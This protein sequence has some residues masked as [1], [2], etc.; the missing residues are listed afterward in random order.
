MNRK[1]NSS[2]VAPALRPA[3]AG[4]KPG[5]PTPMIEPERYELFSSPAYHFDLNRREF[6]KILGGGLLIVCVMPRAEAGQEAGARVFRRGQPLPA[7]I[8]AWLHIGENGRVTV[9]TGKVE[10]GQN[11]RTSLTQAVA[12]ELR[13]VPES[14]QMVMGDTDLTPYDMGTFGSRTTPTM[15]PELRKAASAALDA[16]LD[17]AA[18]TWGVDKT[19]LSAAAGKITDPASGRSNEYAQ[20]LKGKELAQTMPA[21]DPLTPP[22]RWTVMG[23]PLPKVDGRDFV[24]GKHKYPSDISLPGMLYG[25]IL[26]P[27]SLGA[28]LTSIDTKDAEGIEGVTVVHDGDF[29]GVAAPSP[30][31]A[32]RALVAIHADWKTTPQPSS[33]ELFEYLK[34]NV[35][36]ETGR[37]R[38]ESPH[39]TGSIEDA[40]KKADQKSAQ[41]YTVAY[42]AHTPLEP[43]AAVA[44]WKDGKLNVWTGTQRPFGVKGELAAAFHLPEDHVRVRM[45]DT[46]AG[47]GGKHTG[48][49][50]IEAARLAR[51]ADRPVKLVW[52]REE[53]FTW[54][55]FRPAGLIEVKG[56]IRNDGT[57]TG[58][59]FHNYNSGGSGIE[60]P[61]DIANQYIEFHPTKYPLRQGSYRGLAATANHFARESHMDDLAHLVKMDPL[62]FRLKN[63][64]NDRLKAVFQA[65]A[66]KF[67]WGKTTATAERGFGIAGG[68]EKGGYIATCAEVK[69]NRSNGEVKIVRVVAAFECGAVVNP[70]G[71]QNQVEGANIMGIGGALFEHIDFADGRILNGRLSKYR[72][73]RFSDV[74]AIEVVLVDRKD[75]PSAG[76]GE[77]PLIGLAPAVGNAIFSAAG[78]RLRSLPMAP[79]GIKL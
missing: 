13:V 43:R 30:A 22:D 10:M 27:T 3:F 42:I 17:L 55:Y 72:V 77:T 2:V 25:R 67:R 78:V 14:I 7:K 40:W 26:R 57:I 45:P 64:K 65:A 62:E 76:A 36:E 12:E 63:L 31:L 9:Y 5:A 34:Q 69:L 4:L 38:R 71:L 16:L 21:E 44:E 52:T 46:G 35:E 56:G 11:I 53:E 60:S 68:V 37:G 6:F 15:N 19:K 33:K 73:P 28:T 39:T 1:T 51:A 59:E 20:L 8:S 66:E 41:T 23:Q 61:Y 74:P 70:D 54:A 18:K 48:E 50:A 58:W 75:L 32:A 47:Y 24:T 49:C 79:V 29:V